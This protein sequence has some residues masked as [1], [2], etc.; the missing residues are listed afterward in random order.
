M[1][2]ILINL[3]FLFRRFFIENLHFLHSDGVQS[4]VQEDQAWMVC[5]AFR[6]SETCPCGW[7]TISP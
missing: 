2:K 5:Q 7:H 4:E 3:V 1:K 6:S